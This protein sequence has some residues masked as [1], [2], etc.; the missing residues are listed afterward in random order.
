MKFRNEWPDNQDL[1]TKL[2]SWAVRPLEHRCIL[3]FGFDAK[4]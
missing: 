3:K 2:S 4:L 1:M